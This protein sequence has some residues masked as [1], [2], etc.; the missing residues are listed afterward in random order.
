MQ[1]LTVFDG[2]Q[3]DGKQTEHSMNQSLDC[4]AYLTEAPHQNAVPPRTHVTVFCFLSALNSF[5]NKISLIVMVKHN[6]LQSAGMWIRIQGASFPL[7]S[8][9]YNISQATEAKSAKKKQP[10][11]SA[12]EAGQVRE[13][14]QLRK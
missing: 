4:K 14:L 10:S 6:P 5:S 3:T 9:S 11:D 13:T 2:H 12:I 8:G 7:N 1:R